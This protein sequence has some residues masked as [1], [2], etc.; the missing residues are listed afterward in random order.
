[1]TSLHLQ[2]FIVQTSLANLAMF[3]QCCVFSTPEILPPSPS[4]IRLLRGI[5]I[6]QLLFL[7]KPLS[8]PPSWIY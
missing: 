5:Q 3:G 8:W 2:H 1:M 4:L 7:K 6:T